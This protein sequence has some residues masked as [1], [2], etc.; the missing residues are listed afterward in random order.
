[1]SK[2]HQLQSSSFN[3]ESNKVSLVQQQKPTTISGSNQIYQVNL[4]PTYHQIIPSNSLHSYTSAVQAE[5]TTSG[6]NNLLFMPS[7]S[8]NGTNTNISS[9]I[10]NTTQAASSHIH[11]QPPIQQN[12]FN[13]NHNNNTINGNNNSNMSIISSNTFS[14]TLVSSSSSLNQPSNGWYYDS[15]LVDNVDDFL[16]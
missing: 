16:P 15:L 10:L 6:A 12:A 7:L 13:L 11:Q 8:S 5:P 2:N 3:Q 1:M 4:P 9:S 14:N